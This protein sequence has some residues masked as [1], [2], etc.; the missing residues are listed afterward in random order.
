ME[1]IALWY[2]NEAFLDEHFHNEADYEEYK[3]SLPEEVVQKIKAIVLPQTKFKAISNIQ[4]YSGYGI[5]P[6]RVMMLIGRCDEQES[7][8]IYHEL[9]LLVEGALGQ[10]YFNYLVAN[11]FHISNDPEFDAN[12]AEKTILSYR[13]YI[14][15]QIFFLT[16]V[17]GSLK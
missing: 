12:F 17:V 6:Q 4:K 2:D 3:Q 1:V 8:K 5:E 15:K 7:E 13:D 9:S 11:R 16:E 10:E 14:K